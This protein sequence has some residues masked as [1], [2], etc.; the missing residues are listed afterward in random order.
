MDSFIRALLF[1]FGSITVTWFFVILE[2]MLVYAHLS[3]WAPLSDFADSFWQRQHFT[4]Q[5]NLNFWMCLMIMSLRRLAQLLGS[6]IGWGNC[7]SSEVRR[8]KVFHWHGSLPRWDCKIGFRTTRW[9]GMVTILSSRCG[10]NLASL[11]SLAPGWDPEPSWLI[12]W[13]PKLGKKSMP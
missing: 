8:R 7:L 9:S 1:S 6:I 3:K 5:L 11:L 4:S 13:G 2:P 12:G 10:Y